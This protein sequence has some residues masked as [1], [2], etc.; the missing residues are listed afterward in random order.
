MF[1]TENMN[2]S[3]SVGFQI[4]EKFISRTK[5]LNDPNIPYTNIDYKWIT[6]SSEN[7]EDD[8]EKPS[9][10]QREN[11]IAKIRQKVNEIL[12]QP[13]LAGI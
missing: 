2:C 7:V 8:L 1:P 12:K 10:I 6:K 13:A 4:N 11:K 3:I 9:V 5:F